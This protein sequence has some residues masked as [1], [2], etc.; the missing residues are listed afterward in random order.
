MGHPAVTA[1]L[2]QRREAA[3][4]ALIRHYNARDDWRA[5]V[6]DCGELGVVHVWFHRAWQCAWYRLESLGELAQQSSAAE[7]SAGT[8]SNPALAQDAQVGGLA[9]ESLN[10]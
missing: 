3:F 8:G 5:H 6:V 10:S 9:V 1:E 4:Y 2:R 7:A